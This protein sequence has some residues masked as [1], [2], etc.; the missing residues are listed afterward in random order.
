MT[1]QIKLPWVNPPYT[2][3][4][5]HNACWVM[6][7]AKRPKAICRCFGPHGAVKAAQ[8]VREHNAHDALVAA[9]EEWM[10]YESESMAHHPCPD[11]TLKA[12][13]RK[14]AIG[15]SEAALKLAK[16]E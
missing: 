4:D 8:I 3:R 5:G 9:C 14:K 15:L 13:Y 6:D 10:K 12:D 7:G 11:Y 1:E 2:R 16:G